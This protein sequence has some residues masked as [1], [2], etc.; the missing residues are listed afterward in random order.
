MTAKRGTMDFSLT[1]E[2]RE[3][4][5]VTER[6]ARERLVPIWSQEADDVGVFLQEQWHAMAE[7]GLMGLPFPE[8]Y[9]GGGADATTFCV[10]SEALGRAGVDGGT[11]LSY[12][13]S[14]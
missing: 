4:M 10:A 8:E 5:D 13:A 6:F 2:Q 11:M 7:F 9:G 12:G 3:F 14:T 1:D